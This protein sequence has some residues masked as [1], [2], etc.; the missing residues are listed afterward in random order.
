MGSKK[1]F[2]N[3][4]FIQFKN[5]R[6]ARLDLHNL[7][8]H[9]KTT[10]DRWRLMGYYSNLRLALFGL[11]DEVSSE[12]FNSIETILSALDELRSWINS[13]IPNKPSQGG[14]STL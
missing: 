4:Q 5:Y 11:V 9:K 14:G 7:T 1:N 6:I 10:R 8:I 3:R 12:D 13:T 2:K